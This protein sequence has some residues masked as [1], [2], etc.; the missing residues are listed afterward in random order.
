MYK[1]DY[2][3]MP[4][5]H[6]KYIKNISRDFSILA[7]TI[8]IKNNFDIENQNLKSIIKNSIDNFVR[9][10]F[11]SKIVNVDE[12]TLDHQNIRIKNILMRYAVPANSKLV[13]NIYINSLFPSYN[14]IYNDYFIINSEAILAGVR[15]DIVPYLGW[16]EMSN[17]GIAEFGGTPRVTY[18][19]ILTILEFP[20]AIMSSNFNISNP[21]LCINMNLLS[22]EDA[23]LKFKR[24]R[25][26]VSQEVDEAYDA[27]NNDSDINE[28]LSLVQKAIKEILK[29]R[30]VEIGRAHV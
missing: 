11:S 10:N 26:D 4:E 27:E 8:D 7:V 2:N 19:S 6:K 17:S 20:E 3:D 14:L 9:E 24:M 5:E 29:G 25:A 12:K 23:L 30:I 18:G 13:M 1:K 21:G 28:N 22:K 15:Q 16:F